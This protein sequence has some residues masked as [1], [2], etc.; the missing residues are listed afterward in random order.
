MR[1]AARAMDEPLLRLRKPVAGLCWTRVL[2]FAAA[3]AA[4]GNGCE[5]AG[6][7]S[8]KHNFGRFSGLGTPAIGAD[9][10]VYVGSYNG[11]LYA[12]TAGGEEVWSYETHDSVHG[13][14]TL[15]P[16]S[17]VY[18]GSYDKQLY[19][20]NKGGSFSGTTPQAHGSLPRP[21]SASMERS[22]SALKIT[23]CMR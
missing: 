11:R 3:L 17:T 8:W 10:M 16:D 12:L 18:F 23:S 13:T 15:A 19:A 9:G 20:L 22:T 5:P 7:P 1:G 21:Q 14:P 6:R 2:W 4:V